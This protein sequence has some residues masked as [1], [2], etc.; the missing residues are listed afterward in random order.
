[1]AAGRVRAMMDDQGRQVDEATPAMPVEVLGL[2]EVPQAGDELIAV[3]DERAARELAERLR[4]Q[5]REEEFTRQ[6]KTSLEDLFRQVQ[7]GERKELP[8]ILKGD[9][10]GSVEALRESLL[11]LSNEEVDVKVIHAA[12][13]GITKSDVDLAAT[14]NA[15]I[16]GFNVRPDSMAR[17]AAEQEQ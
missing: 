5:T 3:E 2:D 14:A 7:E 17:K 8:I 6:R 13:G 11:K 15:V 12:V 10:Q 9:V 16:I 1:T 4:E